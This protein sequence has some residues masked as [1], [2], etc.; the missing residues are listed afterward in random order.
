MSSLFKSN[1]AGA[2]AQV[3]PPAPMPDPE[4]AGADARRR[5]QRDALARAG[6]Q[7]TIL[8]PRRKRSED[9]A[10]PNFDSYS[11]GKLGA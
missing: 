11:A 7:S 2:A 1:T 10:M 4:L 6:R 9:G 8:T 3:T 5:A